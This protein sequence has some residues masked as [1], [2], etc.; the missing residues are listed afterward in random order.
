MD[1]TQAPKPAPAP[2]AQPPATPAAQQP[3]APA[4]QPQQPARNTEP[5]NIMEGL[6]AAPGQLQTIF[7]GAGQQSEPDMVPSFNEPVDYD[8]RAEQLRQINTLRRS[9]QGQAPAPPQGQA[10]APT[11]E[12]IQNE[13]DPPVSSPSDQVPTDPA[14]PPQQQVGAAPQQSNDRDGNGVPDTIQNPDTLPPEGEEYQ[15]WGDFGLGLGGVAADIA[16][17]AP[18]WNRA[19]RM[20]AEAA[21]NRF[22]NFGISGAP[23]APTGT[24]IPFTNKWIGPGPSNQMVNVGKGTAASAP[25]KLTKP[26]VRGAEKLHSGVEAAK[27]TAQQF[28]KPVIEKT[29]PVVDAVKS[30]TTDVPR[31]VA[32]RLTGGAVNNANQARE[33]SRM[34]AEATA[35][36][37]AQ[38]ADDAVAAGSRLIA[39]HGDDALKAGGKLGVRGAAKWLGPLGWA[40][41]GGFQAYDVYDK[42]D[43][44]AS[45][46]GGRTMPGV[47][48]G[49]N[50]SND[51]WAG[52]TANTLANVWDANKE[53]ANKELQDRRDLLTKWDRGWHELYMKP[54]DAAWT[55][56]DPVGSI[57]GATA[58]TQELT[59]AGGDIGRGIY[60]WATDAKGRHIENQQQ[61]SKA[62]SLQK[63]DA[64]GQQAAKLQ[65]QMR[66]DASGQVDPAMQ[67]QYDELLARQQDALRMAEAAVDQTKDWN[68][69]NQGTFGGHYPFRDAIQGSNKALQQQIAELEK[70]RYKYLP[71]SSVPGIGYPSGRSTEDQSRNMLTPAEQLDL[72]NMQVRQRAYDRLADTY[73]KEVGYFGSGDMPD[74]VRNRVKGQKTRIIEIG[75]RLREPAVQQNPELRAQLQ[76][77][78]RHHMQMLKDYQSWAAA[79]R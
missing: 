13:Y 1:Q 24:R 21:G 3:A 17:E 56:M 74:I 10:P 9:P 23:K 30:V 27:S 57:H 75:Q 11:Q 51:N 50:V 53:V 79:A 65:Q 67:Q 41:D 61:K 66:P 28:A 2:A 49:M 6:A 38:T 43:Q 8:T 26:I 68:I 15:T 4:A 29:K 48:S 62:Q 33:A 54:W 46:K 37:T 25:N 14:A 47:L 63:A 72:E 64:Y 44:I 16:G 31:N 40:I 39:Q 35:R 19:N 5:T 7:G 36:A 60:N 69:G 77:D 32:S 76:A 70:R 12:Q 55:V 59:E 20:W 78:L 34:A 73:N 18:E 22:G 52:R 45:G 71:H 42:Y 58:A